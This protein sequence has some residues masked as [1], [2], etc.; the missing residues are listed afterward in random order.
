VTTKRKLMAASFEDRLREALTTGSAAALDEMS[1]EVESARQSAEA[2]AAAAMKRSLDPLLDAAAAEAARTEAD[3]AAFRARRVAEAAV[4]LAV[5]RQE[6]AAAEGQDG[7]MR[8]YD[9]AKAQ[10]DEAA[11]RLAAEYP[12][13]ANRLG[14][15]LA[16][17]AQ[18]DAAVEA[19]NWQLP[20]GRPHLDRTEEVA[21]PGSTLCGR[22]LVRLSLPAYDP[23]EVEAVWG[24]GTRMGSGRTF[25]P[26][27][28]R[29]QP[30]GD[31]DAA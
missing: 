20:D 1:R 30:G 23:A 17:V 10:R 21:R 9:A 31:G 26:S 16:L 18:A 12:V 3:D 24:V 11:R 6:I 8:T 29:L 15:L 5:R 27:V 25:R 22:E 14:A 7:R 28:V 19:A 2:A 13:L 4:R